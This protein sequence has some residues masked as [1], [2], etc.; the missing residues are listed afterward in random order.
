MN[1]PLINKRASELERLFHESK[2][3]PEL[4]RVLLAELIHR[5][6]PRAV[7]LRK[8]VEDTLDGKVSL[9]N[10][11][12]QMTLWPSPPEHGTPRNRSQKSRQAGSTKE[13]FVAPEIFTTIQPLGVAP[14]PT[15]FR[16]ELNTEITL[17]IG[18]SDPLAKKY[19]VALAALIHEMR[20]RRTGHQ[21]FPLEDGVCIPTDARGTSYQ[22]N[23]DEEANIFEG[24]KIEL[25]VGGRVVKGV[26]TAI[27][28]KAIIVTLQEDFG[29]YISLCILRIDNT[30]LLQALHDRIGDI[31][32]GT[33]DPFHAEIAANVLENNNSNVRTD[34]PLD[35]HWPW[36]SQRPTKN[37]QRF[38]ETALA[39]QVS[40]L[41]GPPGTGKTDTLAALT[42]LLYENNKRVLICSN[43]NQAVD[44]LLLKLCQKLKET[45]DAALANGCILRL[46]RIEDEL[47]KRFGNC[48][49]LQ[50]VVEHK[51]SELN[52]EKAAIEAQRERVEQQLKSAESAL[53]TW[54]DLDVERTA[55]K[56]KK[57]EIASCETQLKQH[58]TE[59]DRLKRQFDD[60]NRELEEHRQA[61]IIRRLFL[62][63]VKTVTQE[64]DNIK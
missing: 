59:H 64:R 23:F 52:L 39:N 43:T 40:W 50:S 24:A 37:Q 36:D 56:S 46:G 18:D 60:L 42:Q 28:D 9:N 34:Q 12:T 5:S 55:A 19:R 14:R 33:V 22:F 44:Q 51:S 58:S 62:R 15:A 16:P 47:N 57:N 49:T 11:S 7:K 61:G 63:D 26:L 48:I 2:D 31:E 27:M 38:L 6:R 29:E 17:D 30:A 3:S 10:A 41:W 35:V 13:R 8:M 20:T 21:R 53:K 4:L 1:R 54:D 25:I 45:N 32:N